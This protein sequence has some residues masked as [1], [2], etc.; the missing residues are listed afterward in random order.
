MNRFSALQ[1]AAL[2]PAAMFLVVLLACNPRSPSEPEQV[3][4]PEPTVQ[5]D[6]HLPGVAVVDPALQKDLE[7]ARGLQGASYVP[8]AQHL[9]DDGSP[10]FTNRLIRESSPYLLQ[11]AHNPVNWYAW[12]DEAFERAKRENKPVFLSIGYSTCH[13][14]HV[15]ERESFEDEE[16]AAFLNRHFIAIKVDREERPDVDSVYMT[17]V[18]ILT[19]RGGWPMTIIM[20]PDK[21]PFFGGTYFPPRRGVRGTGAGLSDILAEMLRIYSSEPERV[22]ARARELSQRIEQMAATQPGPGVP[23]DEVIVVA[24]QQ[25]ATMF[26]RVDGGFAGAPKFPQPPRLSLLLRYARRTGD[27]GAIAMVT[28][29]LDKMAAGGIYDQIG[30]GFHRYSTD[31]QW[32]IPHFE[33]M[34]YDNAQLALVYLEAWQQTGDVTYQ[35]VAREILDYVAREMTSPQG[36]FYSATDADSL[37]PSG[38]EEEGW[39]FTWTVG[40]LTQLLGA[41]DAAVASSVYGVTQQGNLEGRNILHL[42][43]TNSEVAEALRVSPAHVA[44]VLANARRLLY[45]ARALR[46]PPIRDEKIITAWNGMMISAFA[47]AGWAFDEARYIDLAVRASRFILEQ[48]R[49]PDGSLVRTYRAGQKAASTFLDD[50]AF[51]VGACLDLYEA[52]GDLNWL[53][54]AIA[55]QT[56][57]DVRFHDPEAGGYFL[58]S[59]DAET[60]LVREKPAYDGAVP[61]G[62]SVSAENLLRLHDFTG[63]ADRRRSAERLFASLGFGVRRSPTGFSSLL[64]ALDHYYDR[65][66]EIAVIAPF[67]RQEADA[68]VERLRRT[69]V[70]NLAATVLTE[71]EARQQQGWIPWLEGKAALQGRSTAFVCERG[72]CELPTS[73]P[74]AFQTQIDRHVPYPSFAK[75]PPPRLLFERAK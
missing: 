42:A 48:M 21:E 6:P 44:E 9:N 30:G 61:S 15:M 63:D 19:G 12:S 2:S 5:G 24:A 32:L 34:L 23:S 16:I 54:T 64:V 46:P 51:M 58:T 28:G 4:K 50:Y 62:N 72:R 69:L 36:A 70:P 59:S 40:E 1:S 47:R 38:H 13:W 18:N 75:T 25:L 22:V 41:D 65:P 7:R 27:P 8:R 3:P 60:L 45:D 10:R 37:A 39:F 20:T 33:K 11:H 14:C 67:S 52:T 66:F 35:R 68:L 17:A 57:Q 74:A 73:S 26:D 55:L 56:G 71:A 53:Q 43:R 29:T 31:A 49:A